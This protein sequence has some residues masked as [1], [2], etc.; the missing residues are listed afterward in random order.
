LKRFQKE[1]KKKRGE[2]KKKYK[3]VSNRDCFVYIKGE[4]LVPTYVDRK[5]KQEN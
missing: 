4:E 3:D 1:R 2:A 5:K